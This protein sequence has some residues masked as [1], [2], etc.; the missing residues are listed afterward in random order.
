MQQ[1]F[2]RAV[3]EHGDVVLR[4]CRSV[5]GRH[6][7]ADDAWSETFLAA[8][9]SWPELP[10]STNVQAWLVRVA[11][12]KSIDIIRRRAA[13]ATPVGELPEVPEKAALDPDRFELWLAVDELP[14]RQRDAVAY[15]HLIG[16]PYAQIAIIVDSN[17]AAVRRA[18]ADGLRSLRSDR[19]LSRYEWDSGAAGPGVRDSG[20]AVP[21]AV[22]VGDGDSD[23]DG[24]SDGDSNRGDG[25]AV[26][27]VMED[28]SARPG[29]FPTARTGSSEADEEAED[30]ATGD[31][32]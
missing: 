11:K 12:R 25:D 27:R 2:D 7:D 8:L 21:N 32:R 13:G 30:P 1:P 17:A 28:R 10:E 5:L 9:R 15:H 23:S 22:G 16:L 29:R 6:A 20:L 26:T 31:Q 14:P 24:D 3:R 18:A 4:I 19:R